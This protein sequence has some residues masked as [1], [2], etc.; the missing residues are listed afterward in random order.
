MNDAH[1]ADVLRLV[2]FFYMQSGRPSQAATLYRALSLLQPQDVKHA[3]SLAYAYLSQG[4]AEHALE[5]LDSIVGPNEP[6][7]EVHLMRA[8]ALAALDR[9]DDAQVSMRAFLS[10]RR[11]PPERPR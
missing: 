9:I 7:P 2:A 6:S 11:S 4:N 10:M 3:K 8:Q 1:E 5:M